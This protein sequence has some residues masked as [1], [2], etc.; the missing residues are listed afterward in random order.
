MIARA[1]ANVPDAVFIHEDIMS[2]A[3][4]PSGIEAAVAFF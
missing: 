2:V 4:P 3:F 1:Q